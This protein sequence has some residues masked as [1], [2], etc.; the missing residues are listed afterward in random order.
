[1]NDCLLACLIDSAGC[2]Q[3][4]KTIAERG[5]ELASHSR[6]HSD[7]SGWNSQAWYNQI[8]GMREDLARIAG[9]SVG[10]VSECTSCTFY[11]HLVS[12]KLSN[13]SHFVARSGG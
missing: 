4:V 2:S 6:D 12:G 8:Q 3:A 5:H 10:E 7:P 9:I 13:G 11:V 1:M